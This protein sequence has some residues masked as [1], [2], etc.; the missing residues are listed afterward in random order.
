MRI[1]TVK[2]RTFRLPIL[3][4]PLAPP[5]RHNVQG[6]KLSP[7]LPDPNVVFAALWV[8]E[9]ALLC[10]ARWGEALHLYGEIKRLV[11]KKLGQA[12][13]FE[14]ERQLREQRRQILNRLWCRIKQGRVELIGA[15]EVGWLGVTYGTESGWI[16]LPEFLGLNGAW[17][18]YLRGVPL[19][20]LPWK[21]HPA[22]GVYFPT[23][24]EHLLLFHRWL[25]EWPERRRVRLAVD[26]GCGAGVLTFY[27]LHH[28]RHHCRIVAT[29]VNPAACLSLSEDLKRIGRTHQVEVMLTELVPEG[30][31]EVDLLVCNPP[32]VPGPV[33]N[34]VEAAVYFEGPVYERLLDCAE[35]VLKPDGC[36][37]VLYST[38]AIEAGVLDRHPIESIL[39]TRPGLVGTLVAEAR[40]AEPRRR[41]AK[42]LQKIRERE[43]V[44][45]W[46]IRKV[47]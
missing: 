8:G 36:L 40:V 47:G 19:P 20:G 25:Q 5:L 22:Y 14:S 46:L 39:R 45:L 1:A 28:L 4:Q 7:P 10:G 24:T 17:Q 29:D 13:D 3:P 37:V 30:L 23:R 33:R 27:L 12:R 38:F 34:P 44:Q 35:R 42:W 11:E 32:W 9:S 31:S 26:V 43:R 16:T 15:P 6:H 2:S 18:W 41:N 21:L